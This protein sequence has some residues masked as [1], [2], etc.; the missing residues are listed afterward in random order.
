MANNRMAKPCE[1]TVFA[2]TQ[3][4]ADSVG[5]FFT[6]SGLLAAHGPQCGIGLLTD[7]NQHA[8]GSGFERRVARPQIDLA[9]VDLALQVELFRSPS[10]SVVDGMVP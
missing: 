8:H 4:V 10:R 9:E 7:R 6:G 2:V 3:E 1:N 5:I